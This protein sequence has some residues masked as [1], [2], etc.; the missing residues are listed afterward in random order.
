MSLLMQNPSFTPLTGDA[1]TVN[2]LEELVLLLG[3]EFIK[4]FRSGFLHAFETH[5]QVHLDTVHASARRKANILIL[6]QCHSQAF[7]NPA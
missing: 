4:T 2:A 1:N 5:L 6:T 3:D 7:P